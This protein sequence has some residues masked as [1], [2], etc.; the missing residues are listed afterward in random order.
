L[1]GAPLF[2][3]PKECEHGQRRS[4]AHVRQIRASARAGSLQKSKIN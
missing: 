2:V 1:F 3:R 4:L